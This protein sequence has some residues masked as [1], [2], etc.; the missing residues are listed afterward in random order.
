MVVEVIH[1]LEL[2]IDFK[3]IHEDF[4]YLEK[5][6]HDTGRSTVPCLY[7]DDNPMFESRDIID[8]LHKNAERLEKAYGS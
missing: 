8:W 6:R 5:L 2:K 7:I 4:S 3:N 1:Q